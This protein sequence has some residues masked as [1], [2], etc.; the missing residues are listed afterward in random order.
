MKHYTRLTQ[1]FG[2]LLCPWTQDLATLTLGRMRAAGTRVVVIYPALYQ[3]PCPVPDP[4]VLEVFWPR[5]L[6][7]TP[8]PDTMDPSHLT[9][10]MT[11][12]LAHHRNMDTP[13]LFVSQVR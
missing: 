4:R 12:H 7:P 10:Y 9:S 6:C 1:L 8:W 11:T 2:E 5:A 13:S 3:Q